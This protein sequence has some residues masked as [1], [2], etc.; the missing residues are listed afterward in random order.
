MP[1][2]RITGRVSLPPGSRLM[3]ADSATMWAAA[4]APAG[5]PGSHVL[6]KYRII[7]P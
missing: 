3:Y 6:V 5:K 1:D 4:A 7:R 2:G